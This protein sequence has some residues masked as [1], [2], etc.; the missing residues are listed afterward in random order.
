MPHEALPLPDARYRS[1][2]SVCGNIAVQDEQPRRNGSRRTRLLWGW[3]PNYLSRTSSASREVADTNLDLIVFNVEHGLC[4]FVRTPSGHGVMIDV[5]CSAFFKPA[6][7]LANPSNIQLTPHQG[8]RLSSLVVT[9]PHDDHVE[10]I[11]SLITHLRPAVL[12][13]HADYN[14]QEILNPPDGDPSLNAKQY[15]R[16]QQSYGQP[17]IEFPALGCQFRNFSLRPTQAASLGGTTQNAL[18]NSSYVSVLT[19]ESWKIVICGDNEEKGLQ[20]LLTRP[21][22]VAAI[23]GASVLVTPHHGHASGY[24]SAFVD[25][26]GCTS[27]CISSVRTLD[28]HVD[29]R[30]GSCS[31]G[32]LFNGQWR[33][34]LT[35]RSDGHIWMTMSP[36]GRYSFNTVSAGLN[37]L[38]RALLTTRNGD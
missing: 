11:D 8:H 23:S 34:H 13:R 12:Y 16:W 30:Y 14:W 36:G 17:V 10:G 20:A 19:T 7:W 4:A 18:N 38:L 31:R 28:D 37:E 29:Q 22:F 2:K 33:S 25:A 32:V 15:H 21:D 35:T 27:L 24:C 9:H 26:L 6:E 3:I 1:G 5:G